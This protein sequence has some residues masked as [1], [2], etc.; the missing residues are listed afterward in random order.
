MGAAGA[1]GAG[2][3]IG[4]VGANEPGAAA[5]A[6][7]APVGGAFGAA[8]GAAPVAFGFA[9]AKAGGAAVLPFA[10]SGAASAVN[11]S[12]SEE[13]R[14]AGNTKVRGFTVGQFSAKPSR[15]NRPF[16]E[17]GKSLRIPC[18]SATMTQ[19]ARPQNKPVSTT[20]GT[21]RSSWSIG[22]GSSMGG[23]ATS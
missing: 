11:G 23:T 18:A 7:L 2:G 1:A 3:A 4:A 14:I 12:A 21:R 5:N 13:I 16:Q 8:R 10:S 6:G 19:S 20:P 9:L 15:R 17:P 22:M